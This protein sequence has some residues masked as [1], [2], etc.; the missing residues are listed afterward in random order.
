MDIMD[1]VNRELDA[2]GEN[3][4]KS[5]HTIL[6]DMTYISSRWHVAI[7]SDKVGRYTYY[8]LLIL[9]SRFIVMLSLMRRLS[10]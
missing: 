5:R 10:I 8:V 9:I 6:D 7:N 3:L 1:A 2:R 4:V